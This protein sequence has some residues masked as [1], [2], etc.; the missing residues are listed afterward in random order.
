[1]TGRLEN[2]IKTEQKIK[3]TLKSLPQIVADFYYNISTST[4][5]KSC[6]M[7]IMIIKGFIEFIEELNI[8]VN[9]IDETVVTRYLKTKEQKTNKEGQV[10]STSFSY[11]KVVYAALNN[12]LFYLKKKKIIKDNPMDEIKPVRNSDNVK[13]IRLTANDMENI[14]SAVDR[15]V[16]SHRAIETQRPWRSRDKAI[17][18]LF[19]YTGMRET[20]LTEINLNEI[21]FENNTFKIID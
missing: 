3:R 17:L 8:S 1:M 16:G 5:P 4:E 15:G 9:D 7:Y 6:Y 20:A 21:D 11:R 13:R 2:Q 18:L 14:I 12:F 10:Q 19:I